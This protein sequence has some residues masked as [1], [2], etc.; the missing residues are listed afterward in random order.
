MKRL[1]R[2]A[3]AAWLLAMCLFLLSVPSDGAPARPGPP[4]PWN[5]RGARNAQY[6]LLAW[7]DLGMHCIS[8]R[9]DTMAI[10]P[11]YNNLQAQVVRMG[12]PPRIVTSGIKLRYYLP[13]NTTV[14]GKTD[15][16]THAKALFGVDLQPGVGLTGNGLSGEFKLVGNHFEATGIPVLPLD[17][18]MKWD[19]YQQ[20]VVAL[21]I[22]GTVIETVPVVMPVSDELHC[23]KCHATGEDATARLPKLPGGSSVEENILRLHDLD[24]GTELMGSRPVLCASCHADNALGAAGQ[25][26]TPNLSLAM[27]R[28]HSR[29][30]DVPTCYDCHPGPKTQCLRTA[31]RGM[32]RG[33]G[34][35]NKPNCARCH[36]DL[37]ALAKGLED[38]R[39]P[40][41]TEPTCEQCH[42]GF[43]TDQPLYRNSTGHHG[44]KCAACHNSPHA[45]WPS[46]S[47]DDSRLPMFVQGTRYP[48][49][50]NRCWICHPGRRE[51]SPHRIASQSL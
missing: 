30:G 29:V 12:D 37:A 28:F 41:L 19:P 31:I 16:W 9:F 40:W 46:K 5:S 38:G 23:E 42:K 32:S 20:A 44:I 7:N 8:P 45:W 15:F 10:L 49:A 22:D 18:K 24:N 39:E 51:P 2:L 50:K 35:K 36:G 21:E 13:K 17:D 1:V 48:I 43:A 26:E 25:A 34:A 27:H 47:G 3:M 14:A 4:N 33:P 6:V 11:P